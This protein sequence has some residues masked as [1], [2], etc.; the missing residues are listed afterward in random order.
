MKLSVTHGGLKA[1]L[2]SLAGIVEKKSS[3]PALACVKLRTMD[4]LL[5]V[6]ASDM[7]TRKILRMEAIIDEPGEAL[8]PAARLKD[9]IKGASFERIEL[10]T[11]PN[12]RVEFRAGEYLVKI[13]GLPPGEFPEFPA[14]DTVEMEV[15]ASDLHDMVRACLHAASRDET[16]PHLCGIRL[17]TR[18]NIVLAVATDGRRL[19]L[20]GKQMPSGAIGAGVAVPLKGAEEILRLEDAPV[21]FGVTYRHVSLVQGGAEVYTRLIEGEY[22]DF[23]KAIPAESPIMVTI[24]GP[25]FLAAVKR[26]ALFA[27]RNGI[28]LSLQR[29]FV[30]LSAGNG[31]NEAVDSVECILHGPPRDIRFNDRYLIEALSS[32]PEGDIFLKCGVDNAPMVIIPGNMAGWDERLYLLSPKCL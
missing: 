21:T 2:N 22:P 7:E 30:L 10:E 31:D 6:E 1:V 4:D 13:A 9:A 14:E 25:D 24:S 8:I 17:I 12:D 3:I 18:G 28:V 11:L 26:V 32:L 5:E 27:D 19:S 20:A 23:C 15:E 29:G 16:K